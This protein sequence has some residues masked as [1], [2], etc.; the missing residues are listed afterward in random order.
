MNGYA[1]LRPDHPRPDK[2]KYEAPLGVGN[3]AYF[4]VATIDAIK[5]SAGPIGITEGEKKALASCQAG[6]PCI[7]IAGVWAWQKKR[8]KDEKGKAKGER[9]LI[10]DLA[11]IDWYG[12]QVW[13]CFDTD[14]RRNPSVS[15]AKAELMKILSDHGARVVDVVLPVGRAVEVAGVW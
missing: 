13:I 2:G 4:P 5:D 7:A 14:P 15:Q 1:R 11:E 3:R 6:L 8:Q 10:D 9:E 12:W